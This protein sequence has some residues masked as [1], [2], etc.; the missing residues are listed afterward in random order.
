[1]RETR[2]ETSERTDKTISEELS[3][4]EPTEQDS[5]T[6]AGRLCGRVTDFRAENQG[7]WKGQEGAAS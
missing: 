4:T 2:S 6:E 3:A 7:D 1:M 5:G